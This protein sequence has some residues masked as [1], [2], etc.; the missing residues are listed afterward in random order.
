MSFNHIETTGEVFRIIGLAGIILAPLAASIAVDI[1]ILSLFQKNERHDSFLT[2]MLF[3]MFISREQPVAY[4]GDGPLEIGLTI[5][6]SAIATGGA[7]LACALLGSPVAASILVLA[8]VNCLCLYM[9]GES[10]KELAQ[11]EMQKNNDLPLA[12]AVYVCSQPI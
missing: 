10:L 6:F 12:D 7:A 3:G 8:W 2:G 11:Y 4:F 1:A 9:L 5:A